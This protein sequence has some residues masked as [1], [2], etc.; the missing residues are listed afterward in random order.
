MEKPAGLQPKILDSVEPFFG[1]E[2][3]PRGPV[4]LSLRPLV[5]D[6]DAER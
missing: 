2:R 5:G 6:R 1:C 4:S 3:S